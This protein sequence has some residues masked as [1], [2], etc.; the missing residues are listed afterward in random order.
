MTARQ[1]E[2]K[3]RAKALTAETCEYEP[4]CE[5]TGALWETM[6]HPVDA[7]EY[8]LPGIRGECR[9]PARDGEARS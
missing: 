6:W 4:D 9:D 8:L 3:Q 5:L 7:E 2:L 1:I